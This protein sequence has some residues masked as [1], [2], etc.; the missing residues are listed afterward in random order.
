MSQINSNTK[1]DFQVVLLLSRFVGHPVDAVSQGKPVIY[2]IA[3]DCI[4]IMG[5]VIMASVIMANVFMAN[6][7]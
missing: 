5:S 4:N 6:V 3:T 2:G 7:T 1:D